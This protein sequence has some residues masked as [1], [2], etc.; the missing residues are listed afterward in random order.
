MYD[1]YTSTF[2]ELVGKDNSFIVH[3]YNIQVLCIEL[4]KIYNHLSQTVFSE[5][6]VTNH[7][8]Y[9]FRSQ[10]D[11]VIPELKLFIKG[12]IH[13]GTMDLLSGI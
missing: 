3:H 6:F 10:C 1:D 12:L 8:T 4:Y 13:F 7:T 11:F 9:N 5:L 2:D